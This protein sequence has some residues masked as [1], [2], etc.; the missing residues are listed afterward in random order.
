MGQINLERNLTIKLKVCTAYDQKKSTL[1]FSRETL[2]HMHRETC[3]NMVMAS[4]LAI[5]NN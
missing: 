4:L 5:A 3:E 2:I 1:R